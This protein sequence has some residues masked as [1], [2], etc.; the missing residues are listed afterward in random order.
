MTPQRRVPT[1]LL[2]ATDNAPAF[3]G[4][5]ELCM[6]VTVIMVLTGFYAVLGSGFV[7]KSGLAEAFILSSTMRVDMM[8][9]RA[10]NGRWPSRPGE[11][12]GG[13]L[14]DTSLGRNVAH[15]ELGA[16][17]GLTY[18][19]RGTPRYG[20][21]LANRRLTLRAGTVAGDTGA[22]VS[23]YC[24]HRAAPPGISVAAVDETDVPGEYLPSIC[25]ER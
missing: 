23:W 6:T 12:G 25:R 20:E 15:I 9:F 16:E 7:G 5:L 19:L 1:I 22:P 17:G 10:G 11:L 18:V 14:T 13:Q 24:A 2:I 8:T 21:A 4:A 3:R